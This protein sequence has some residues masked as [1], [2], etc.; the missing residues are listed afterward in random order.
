MKMS[1][2]I[3]ITLVSSM[4]AS[5]VVASTDILQFDDD[6]VSMANAFAQASDQGQGETPSSSNGTLQLAYTKL[7]VMSGAYQQ[8]LYDSGTNSLGMTNTSAKSTA[9]SESGNIKMSSSQDVSQ[10]QSNKKLSETD[11]A[12]LRQAITSS[13]LFEAKDI[14]P[15]DPAGAQDYSLNVISVTM[16][17]RPRTIIWTSTSESVPAGLTS[18]A[19]TIEDLASG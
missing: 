10:S 2:Q 18:I 13:G 14:Y 12:N 1:L 11:Q 3:V 19:K 4:L 16:D 17:N 9:E 15:P 6:T 8:I 5:I 7:G